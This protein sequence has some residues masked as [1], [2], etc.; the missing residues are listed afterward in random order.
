MAETPAELLGDFPFVS[1]AERAHA[2][3]LL[4]LPLVRGLVDGPTPMHV[5][6]K[7][8]PGTGGSLLA[9]L[10]VLVATGRR[11]ASMTEGR[12]ED[13]WRK[14][15][16]AKLLGSPPVFHL[17][18]I[19]RP[20]DSAALAS[21]LTASSWGDR[22]LGQSTTVEVPI[23]CT[24]IATGNNIALSAEMT[25]RSVRIRIDART[26][27]P[28]LRSGFRHADIRKWARERRNPG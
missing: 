2:L 5:I 26:D 14:R 18:N 22:L 4:L 20:L 17:D 23:T 27:R 10:V 12:D 9:E 7:P 28:W 6:D 11:S 19:R 21:A 16:T 8:A 3:A 25:R 15:V 24:W 13:E 1:D